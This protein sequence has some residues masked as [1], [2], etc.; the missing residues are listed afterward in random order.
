MNSFGRAP[1]PCLPRLHSHPPRRIWLACP[2]SLPRQPHHAWS[3]LPLAEVVLLPPRHRPLRTASTMLLL[4]VL[5]LLE[6]AEQA[7]LS[8]GAG[9]GAWHGCFPLPLPMQMQHLL[10]LV[11]R[12]PHDDGIGLH[13]ALGCSCPARGGVW[14]VGGVQARPP[15]LTLT[16][17]NDVSADVGPRT[18]DGPERRD[19][20]LR[21][22]DSGGTGWEQRCKQ[23]W[24]S[25]MHHKKHVT[26]TDQ[27]SLLLLI[28][29][30]AARIGERLLHINGFNGT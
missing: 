24:W 2:S 6:D 12:P 30:A 1:Q 11:H 27:S 17:R 15:R 10:R 26:C 22:A 14:S 7:L 18:S 19:M 16:L 29:V 21:V 25:T 28:P 8:R 23:A 5:R 20:L 4:A 9:A 3:L 13:S